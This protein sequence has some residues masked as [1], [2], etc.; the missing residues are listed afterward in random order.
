MNL[1]EHIRDFLGKNH[2]VRVYQG[3]RKGR[4]STYFT[5]PENQLL[6][7]HFKSVDNDKPLFAHKITADSDAFG[8]PSNELYQPGDTITLTPHG[9]NEVYQM[10]HPEIATHKHLDYVMNVEKTRR[11]APKDFLSIYQAAGNTNALLTNTEGKKITSDELLQQAQQL[12]AQT[13]KH[14]ELQDSM[15]YFIQQ[16]K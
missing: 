16:L 13:I 6:L 3:T 10:E 4:T 5:T 9:I 14:K 1:I 8:I 11:I 7:P 2:D 12:E 15:D